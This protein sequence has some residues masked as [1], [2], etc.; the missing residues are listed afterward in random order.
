MAISVSVPMLHRDLK[1][2][3]NANDVAN[4][5]SINGLMIMK[6]KNSIRRL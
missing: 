4:P 2:R 5:Q 6:N 3:A 1:A